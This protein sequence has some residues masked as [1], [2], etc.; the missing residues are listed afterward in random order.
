MQP[1][2]FLALLTGLVAFLFLDPILAGAG[3]GFITL[4]LLTGLL[5]ATA[6]V[7]GGNRWK[8]RTRLAGLTV[9]VAV[10]WL[11]TLFG[12]DPWIAAARL[13]FVVAF[14]VATVRLLLQV[15]R[16][17]HIT[18]DTL[19]ASVCGYIL[20][21]IAFGLAFGVLELLAPGSLSGATPL[22]AR[23]EGELTYY[24]FVT[25]ATLG[26]GELTPIS[27]LARSMTIVEAIC[28]QFYIAAVVARVV[29][30]YI[31]KVR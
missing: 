16:T 26:F 23:P 29:G 24:S 30:L 6:P 13:M 2:F 4:L 8:S 17:D 11:G 19:F 18:E 21:G 27:S 28:G 3:R 31:N 20:M 25:L 5:I 14:L 15:A 10:V 12:S 1:R 22:S 7:L 9:L